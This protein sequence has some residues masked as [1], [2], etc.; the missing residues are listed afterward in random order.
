MNKRRILSLLMCFTLIICNNIPLTSQSSYVKTHFDNEYE[1]IKMS[2]ILEGN[3]KYSI[4]TLEVDLF[5]YEPVAINDTLN[6]V[7]SDS[8]GFHFTGY[9]ITGME[10]NSGINNS[11]AQHAKQGILE[12]RL[13]DDGLPVVKYLNGEDAGI[14]T[15]KVL[16]SDTE[17]SGD[18]YGKTIYKDIPFE[19]IYNSD[20]GYYEYRSSANHA[21]VNESKTRI[22]LY[23]DTLSTQNKYIKTL[24]LSTYTSVSDLTNVQAASS[25]KQQQLMLEH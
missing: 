2:E 12:D 18:S 13:S 22:E 7:T 21:Q 14:E 16:F 25:F 15:G 17:Y 9:G 3:D 5:D 1:S 10:S 4:E 11:E 19:V 23:D 24:D 6:S 20:T 8:N